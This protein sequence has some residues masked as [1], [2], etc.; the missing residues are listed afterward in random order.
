MDDPIGLLSFPLYAWRGTATGTPRAE[1]VEAVSDATLATSRTE[2]YGKVAF[3]I[4]D[5]LKHRR[6]FE[7]IWI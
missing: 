3:D 7:D 5:F 2:Q 6:L 1:E 4:A